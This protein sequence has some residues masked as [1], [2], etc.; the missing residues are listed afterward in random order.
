VAT[1]A[2]LQTNIADY[3]S[4]ADLT[5]PIQ[6]AIKRAIK[7]YE[8]EFFYFS[9][10]D[11]SFL[12]VSGT[13]AYT[14]SATDGYSSINQVMVNYNGSHYEATRKNLEDFENLNVT[15]S[16]GAPSVYAEKLGILYF[17]PIPNQTMTISVNY[18][19]KIATLSA[20]GDTNVF[21]I[22]AEDLIESRAAWWVATNKTKNKD[23]MSRF[24]SVEL[25]ALAQLRLE[26]KNKVSS[27]RITPSK[28]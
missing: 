25:E 17:Y 10:G 19:A 23:D 20:S 21:T 11:L 18:V 1:Y 12:T 3:F 28:F 8:R 5:T 7:V 26:T 13:Q 24:K 15:N 2:E 9:E 14:L 22:N 27:G 6:R 16:N 4:R